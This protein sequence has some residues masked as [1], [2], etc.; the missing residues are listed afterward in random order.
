ME[1]FSIFLTNFFILFFQIVNIINKLIDF[2]HKVCL[3]ISF[4]KCKVLF[5]K[6]F[7]WFI[8]FVHLIIVFIFFFILFLRSFIIFQKSTLKNIISLWERW[9]HFW[10]FHLLEYFHGRIEST[11]ASSCH[12]LFIIRTIFGSSWQPDQF[13]LLSSSLSQIFILSW[14]PLLPMFLF[15]DHMQIRTDFMKYFSILQFCWNLF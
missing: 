10:S 12:F 4:S 6:L 11:A 8:L 7:S 15:K 3:D 1:Y 13:R 2:Y 14:S 9:N 5:Y